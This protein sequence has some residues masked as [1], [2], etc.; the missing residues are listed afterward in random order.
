MDC[1]APAAEFELLTRKVAHDGIDVIVGRLKR[2]LASCVTAQEADE[3][4]E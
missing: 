3:V 4:R 1:R 2:E